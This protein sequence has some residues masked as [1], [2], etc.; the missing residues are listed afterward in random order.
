MIHL[1]SA[2]W[3]P[4]GF[5]WEMHIC[6]CLWEKKEQTLDLYSATSCPSQ[7]PLRTQVSCC[8]GTESAEHR[9]RS[10]RTTVRVQGKCAEHGRRSRRIT[11]RVQ[12]KWIKQSHVAVLLKRNTQDHLASWGLLFQGLFVMISL[13]WGW[14]TWPHPNPSQPLYTEYLVPMTC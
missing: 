13:N 4:S 7:G 6:L 2:T 12:E 8:S 14:S 3:S 10:R 1:E 11:V 9:R 5:P